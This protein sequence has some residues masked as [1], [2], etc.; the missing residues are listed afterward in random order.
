MAASL[1]IKAHFRKLRDPRRRHGQEH[2]FLDILVIGLCAVIGAANS[3]TGIAVFGR[4][5]QTWFKRFLALPNG[6]PSHDTF[7]RVF[8][9]LDPQAFQACLRQWL[10]ALTG[11]LSLRHIAID[12]KTLRGSGSS[13]LGPLQ[14]VSASASAQQLSLGQVAVAADSNEVTAIPH[15]LELLD[16][17]GALVTIDALGCQKAV[18]QEIVNRGGDY[19]LTVTAN[20]G[21]LLD[22]IQGC[23]SR[24]LDDGVDGRDFEIYAKAERGHGRQER[25]SYVVVRHPEG[26]RQEADWPKLSV[27]G[28]CQSERTVAGKTSSEVRYFIG[29]KQ[30]GARFYGRCL[31][32]HWR[33]ENN[34]HWQ[35]A[36]TFAEDQNRT[37]QR[38]AAENLALMRRIALTLL[39]RHPSK[40]SIRNKRLQA[41][42]DTNFLE[43][44]LRG[45]A[46]SDNL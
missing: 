42:W 46:N 37:A 11:A 44:I 41:G 36:V 34:L 19:V 32:N 25:R 9:R 14:L 30:A 33:I 20:Q 13:D 7:E 1:A 22:D 6:I 3:W 28:M 10:L 45:S 21:Q 4:T 29:S 27:V 38:Q 15:L 23:L 31:R 16:L 24:A 26:I 18:A 2:R 5:H 40:E 17:K 43:E 12:G 8:Q 39:K 35:M